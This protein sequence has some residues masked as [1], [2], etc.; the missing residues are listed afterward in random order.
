MG[1]AVSNDLNSEP[2][3]IADCLVP[4]AA[5]THYARKIEGLSDPAPIFLPLERFIIPPGREKLHPGQVTRDRR[6]FTN[7]L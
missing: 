2:F 1:Y 3:S 5:T 7:P 4:G 6:R